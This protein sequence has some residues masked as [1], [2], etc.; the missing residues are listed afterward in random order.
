[1]FFPI[2]QLLCIIKPFTFEAGKLQCSSF[3]DSIAEPNFT[4][5]SSRHIIGSTCYFDVQR[6]LLL[7]LGSPTSID[8]SNSRA[9]KI[10]VVLPSSSCTIGMIVDLDSKESSTL[11]RQYGWTCE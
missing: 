5:V 1:M 8:S 7:L 11:L 6:L 9:H 4:E 10:E 3:D 2:F